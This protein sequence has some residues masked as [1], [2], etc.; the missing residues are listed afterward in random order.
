MTYKSHLD[1][2]EVIAERYIVELV[3]LKLAKVK[4]IKLEA[5]YWNDPEWKDYYKFQI[6]HAYK[7]TAIYPS[8]AVVKALQSDCG[9]YTLR[10]S[11]LPS[12]II[13]YIKEPESPKT[14]PGELPDTTF[15]NNKPKTGRGK[16]GL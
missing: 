14:E 1:G 10:D 8:E 16:L 6:R 12:I 15:K 9:V 3:S 5:G 11:K 13:K 7:L 2:R 4:K